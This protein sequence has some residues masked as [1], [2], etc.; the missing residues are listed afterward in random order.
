MSKTKTKTDT[1]R[2]L[3]L[4]EPRRNLELI[5]FPDDPS[6]LSGRGFTEA[7]RMK[8]AKPEDAI[9][10]VEYLEE[11]ANKFAV[12]PHL[13]DVAYTLRLCSWRLRVAYSADGFDIETFA[14][15]VHGMR[16][17]GHVKGGKYA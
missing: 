9:Y 1:T 6:L 16:A 4:A 14:E 5:D 13:W 11:T 2:G 7:E 17:W 10:C 3:S 15:P 12:M 8:A